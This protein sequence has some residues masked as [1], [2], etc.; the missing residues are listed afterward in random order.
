MVLNIKTMRRYSYITMVALLLAWPIFSLIPNLTNA[1]RKPTISLLSDSS[2]PANGA[3]VTAGENNT[4]RVQFRS[5]ATSTSPTDNLKTQVF[6]KSSTESKWHNFG[7]TAV[8]GPGG[9]LTVPNNITNV[10]TDTYG[11]SCAMGWGA[12]TPPASCGVLYTNESGKTGYPA[13]SGSPVYSPSV[14]LAPGTYYWRARAYAPGIY[15]SFS[16]QWSFTV[17]PNSP[18]VTD[19]K[20]VVSLEFD[21]GLISQST[22]QTILDAHNMKG[23]FYVSSGRVGQ[24]GYLAKDQLL[25]MQT[26]G[27]EIGSHTIGHVDLTALTADQIKYQ[28]QG[29]KDNLTAMGL[30][31]DD[32]AYPFGSYNQTVQTVTQN[33]G[34]KTGRVVGGIQCSG[35]RTAETIPPL[36]AY[37]TETPSSIKNT[38]TLATMQGYVTKAETSG[39]GWVQIVMHDVSNTNGTYTISPATLTSFLDWL[40]NRNAQGTVVKTVREAMGTTFTPPT[41][42]PASANLLK[43]PSLENDLNGDLAPDNWDLEGWG[44]STYV[45]TRVSDAHEG[46]WGE[47][48]EITSVTSGDRKI[49]STQ[50]MD[51]VSAIP[52]AQP[53]KTYTVTAWY[54]SSTPVA[55]AFYY[56]NTAG[57]WVWFGE[58][59]PMPASADWKQIS[60]VTPALPTDARYVSAG[61]QIEKVGWIIADDFSLAVN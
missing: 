18:T 19:E 9:S 22:A 59:A 30:A 20:T 16:T 6:Y 49:V 10:Y 27:H 2:S 1:A 17:L 37:A 35:C 45:Y 25:A 3:T 42:P 47:K 52:T 11:R 39:G 34:L 33:A 28:V 61:I 54:K 57:S 12:N 50:D 13:F 56:R 38:T 29:D 24:S 23:T 41:P 4:L 7:S 21:D 32:L 31:I 44:T 60:W 14:F 8:S 40:S 58:S 48:L 26:K 51:N 36:D 43:N 55:L 46:S 15:S 53:G 5:V